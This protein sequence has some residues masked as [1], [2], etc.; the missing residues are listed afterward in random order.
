MANVD[1]PLSPGVFAADAQTTVPA[2]PVPGVPY[3]DPVNGTSTIRQGWPFQRLVNSAEFNEVMY[4]VTAL[5]DVVNKTA[6]LAWSEEVDYQ[7]PGAAQAPSFVASTD[8]NLYV[9]LQASGPNSGGPK[10]PATGNTAY[11]SQFSGLAAG[12]DVGDVKAVA[13][14]QPPFGWLKCN[15]EVVSR[16]Q[17]PALFEAIGT[18]F[19]AG[20]GSTTFG[21]PDLRGEFVRGWD[22]GRAIDQGRALGSFQAGQNEWHDHSATVGGSGAHDHAISATAEIGG[23]HVHAITGTAEAAG[24]HAHTAPRA[25]NN[26]VG[27][28]APNFTTANYDNGVTAPT[29]AAGN[30]THAISGSAAA[31]GD[32]THAISGSVSLVGDHAH[33]IS[34][35]PVG[36]NEARPRNVALLY[37]IKY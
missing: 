33:T 12:A 29:H 6:G 26:N 9:A 28:G 2:N 7:G 23:G 14:E 11:W 3:R 22:D 27:G 18:R 24:E 31:A 10:D 13:T 37:V 34:I 32:H 20:N 17:Y 15:G 5:L 8:G 25:Q 21:L 30:H 35:T 16:T 1:R 36:G 19:G 4:R